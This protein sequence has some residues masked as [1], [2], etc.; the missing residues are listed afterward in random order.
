MVFVCRGYI[1]D[2]MF[3]V[4]LYG[5]NLMIWKWFKL[6]FN[7]FI[8]V[9]FIYLVL[10]LGVMFVNMIEDEVVYVFMFLVIDGIVDD[11]VWKDVKWNVMLF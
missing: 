11:D 3:V 10:V 9:V 8:K 6:V 4:K 2:F 1:V 7:I 5:V